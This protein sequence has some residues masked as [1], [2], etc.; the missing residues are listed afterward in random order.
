LLRSPAAERLL[1]G[2]RPSRRRSSST[3]RHTR[4]TGDEAAG[5]A[6]DA[7]R[8]GRESVDFDEPDTLAAYRKSAEGPASA[9]PLFRRGGGGYQA[10]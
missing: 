8:D 7:T 6:M 3:R 10:T 9:G 2:V 5:P 4:S 1:V